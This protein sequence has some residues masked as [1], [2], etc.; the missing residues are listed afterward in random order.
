MNDFFKGVAAYI[1]NLR[2]VRHAFGEFT[3]LKQIN[4]LI[5]FILLYFDERN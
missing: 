5:S 3:L 4:R 2:V 1:I